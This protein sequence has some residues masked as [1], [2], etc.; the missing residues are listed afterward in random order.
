MN[1]KLAIPSMAPG[2]LKSEMSAHFGHADMFTLVDISSGNIT[3]TKTIDN[4]P[5]TQGGCMAPVQILKDHGVNSI[6]VGGLGARPMMG[7]QQA[8]I[9]VIAGAA[10]SVESVVKAYLEGKLA[11]AG[12]DVICG[13]S[14]TGECHH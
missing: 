3:G 7:F 5:H 8:G 1:E 13:H 9:R 6:I 11:A 2:G 10:G 14:K 4:P 12:D